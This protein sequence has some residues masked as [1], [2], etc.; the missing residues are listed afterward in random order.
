[1]HVSKKLGPKG[2]MW[3]QKRNSWMNILQLISLIGSRS[4]TWLD[5]K[6]TFQRQIFSAI[7]DGCRFLCSIL[8]KKSLWDLQIFEFCFH[9]HFTA[10]QLFRNW[11]CNRSD[12]ILLRNKWHKNLSLKVWEFF[13]L[14]IFQHYPKQCFAIMYFCKNH[15]LWMKDPNLKVQK[16]NFT[17]LKAL[18]I[19]PALE[20]QWISC[21][22]RWVNQSELRFRL[23]YHRP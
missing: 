20:C 11:V 16:Y 7:K 6:R 9:L 2:C 8:N 17:T 14:V 10:S 1:M 12:W 3:H 5:V 22:H 23:T 18:C 21:I 15:E 4:V 19:Q 13:C